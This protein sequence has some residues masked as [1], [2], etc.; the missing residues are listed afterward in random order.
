MK[1]VPVN[2]IGFSSRNLTRICNSACLL[3][4]GNSHF[5][6]ILHGLLQQLDAMC[7]RALHGSRVNAVSNHAKALGTEIARPLLVAGGKPCILHCFLSHSYQSIDSRMEFRIVEFAWD[8]PENSSDR[9]DQAKLRRRR[10]RRRSHRRSRCLLR[11]LPARS[12]SCAHSLSRSSR[13]RARP[14]SH[15]APLH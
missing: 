3:T 12:P 2:W 5:A 15:R 4:P 8:T 14:N 13:S 6:L 7:E 10:R 9:S 1:I 11:S